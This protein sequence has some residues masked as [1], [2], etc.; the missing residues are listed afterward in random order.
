M[1]SDTPAEAPHKPGTCGKDF[2]STT[3][4]GTGTGNNGGGNNNDNGGGNNN[5]GGNGNGGVERVTTTINGQ[6][7]TAV[8]TTS[9]GASGSRSASRV[10]ASAS[11]TGGAMVGSSLDGVLG[12]TGLLAVVLGAVVF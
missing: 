7:T 8:R 2:I 6:P 5:G 11:A 3:N 1:P 9:V 12:L 10:G 4:P